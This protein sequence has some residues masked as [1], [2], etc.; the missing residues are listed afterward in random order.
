MR[1]SVDFDELVALAG[2]DQAGFDDFRCG[3]IELPATAFERVARR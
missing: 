1:L 3:R 2:L